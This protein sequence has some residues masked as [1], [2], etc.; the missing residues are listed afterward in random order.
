VGKIKQYVQIEE[1][2]PEKSLVFNSKTIPLHNFISL[3]TLEDLKA[4]VAA[5]MYA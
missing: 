3:G 5:N 1:M 4:Q 2:Q